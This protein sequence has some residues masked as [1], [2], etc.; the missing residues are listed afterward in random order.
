M[1]KIL[2]VML[3]LAVVVSCQKNDYQ[4]VISGTVWNGSK[5]ASADRTITI[6]GNPTEVTVIID[7][8]VTLK[9]ITA[10][11]GVISIESVKTVDGVQEPIIKSEF[12][13]YYA[14]D[15]DLMWGNIMYV[16]PGYWGYGE[17]LE[18]N[19]IIRANKL[20]ESKGIVENIEYRKI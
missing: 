1:K 9:F 10:N 5:E 20:Y 6:D 2:L 12:K 7:Y 13:F 3:F 11:E 19:F 14:Y 8:D 18:S 15:Y 4:M 17:F 16:V